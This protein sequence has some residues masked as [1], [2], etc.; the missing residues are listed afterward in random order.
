MK[1]L[2]VLATA[3]LIAAAGGLA[4]TAS[5]RT[6]APF[7][8]ITWGSLPKAN[9]DYTTAPITNL[10]AGRHECWDRLVVDLDAPPP[11]VPAAGSGYD[12]RYVDQVTEDASGDP[13]PLAGGAFIQVVVHAPTH[14]IDN[15][16]P[17]YNP[18]DELHAVNVSRFST[19]RQVAIVSDFEG[20][21]TIGLGVRARLPFRVFVLA[22][23]GSGS[24]LVIDVAHRW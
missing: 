21:F 12:V 5:A 2:F 9:P 6:N 20:V 8:G 14:D 11:D 24:R 1:R 4:P 22:G 13:V 19:F 23:P 3:V 7:C 16:E 18:P 17:T 10:R 15:G